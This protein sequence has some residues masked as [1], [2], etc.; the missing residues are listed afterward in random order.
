MCADGQTM[1]TT[2]RRSI[3]LAIGVA[4][5]VVVVMLAEPRHRDLLVPPSG[6]LFGAYV[7]PPDSYLD[8]AKRAAVSE[9]ETD[10][11]RTLAVDHHYYP[12]DTPFPG[13]N[14]S[15]D[16]GTDRV[17]MISWHGTST[18]AIRSGSQDRWISE[19]AQA[20]KDLG[21]PVFLRWGWEM[22]GTRNK[23]WVVSPASYVAAWI[24]I[25][26]IFDE[27]GATNAVWV[28]CPSAEAF[29]DRVASSYYPGNAYVDW[30]CADGYN[31]A[32]VKPGTSWRSFGSIFSPF[33][34]W[35]RQTDKPIM[36]GETGVLEG[37]DD[38]KASWLGDVATTL[39]TRMPLVKAFLYFSSITENDGL[40]YDWRTDTSPSSVQAFAALARDPLFDVRAP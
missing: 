8:E 27:E 18:Q 2:R 21:Y 30:V 1:S 11:G 10:I 29:D 38:A 5:L 28:W 7:R 23:W 4:F 17:P 32:P 35:A 37:D 14:E 16:E 20:V 6:V 22:D 12:W 26:R 39:R 13:A 24:H 31:W 34:A 3:G 15:F 33:Y 40:W 36:I 19:R 9:L 25:R